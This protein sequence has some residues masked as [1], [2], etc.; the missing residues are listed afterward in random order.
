M[1]IPAYLKPENGPLGRA[2]AAWLDLAPQGLASRFVVLWFIILYTAFGIISSASV[3]L[4]PDMLETYALGLHPAAGYAGHAPLAPWIA[5]GWFRLFPPTEWAFHLL[6]ALNAAAGLFAI[7]RIARQ[8][9]TGDK[10]IAVLLLVLLMPFYPFVGQ[11][12]G[13]GE[14]VLSTWP[15]ATWCFVRA[16]ATRGLPG[17]LAWSA[18]AGAAAALAVLGNY[19]S[20]FLIAAF[21]T[22]VLAHPGGLT[23]LRSASPWL[24]AAVGA[25]ALVPHAA[26][27]L[28]MYR[29]G[30]A[31]LTPVAD[32]LSTPPDAVGIDALYIAGSV[33]AAGVVLA[34]YAIAVRPGGATLRDTVWPE[35]PDGRLLVILLAVPL[36]LPAVAAPFV[37]AMLTPSWTMAAWFLLPVILLRPKTAVLTR[38]AAIRITALV[39]VATISA[40]LAAPWLAWRRHTEG[41]PEGREYY[42]LIGGEVTNAWRTATGQPL[43]TV[44]GDPAL[45]SAV[46]FYSLD[47]PDPVPGFPGQPSLDGAVAICRADDE[48]CV[49]TAKQ[50]AAGKANAQFMTYSTIN[51]YLGKPGRLGR[52]FFIIAPTGS[53]PVINLPPPPRGAPQ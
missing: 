15:V 33:A 49:D 42:R 41:T 30:N 45:V 9:L 32:A 25:I 17:N 2:F 8:Y 11:G 50:R 36:V 40:L 23:F 35:D 37:G 43:R 52:F 22:A 31:V 28:D 38:T 10:Q 29:A 27:L 7:D 6:A 14:M 53:N 12:F 51:R 20:V 44:M 34:V 26:W 18:A 46:A 16:F 21:A 5:G 19:Y 48:A 3:G 1:S 13:A 24:M 47:H 4:P 39:V